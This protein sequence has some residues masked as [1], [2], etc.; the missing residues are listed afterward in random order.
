MAQYADSELASQWRERLGRFD[1]SDLTVAEFCRL[2]EYSVAAFYYW[3]GKLQAQETP[4]HFPTFVSVDV[5]KA[6]S[7]QS[8]SRGDLRIAIPG[9]AVIRVSLDAS[10]EQQQQLIKNA[11]VALREAQA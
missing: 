4:E 7:N 3:R 9:G 1:R 5:P 10:S 11:I 8:G 2:E 6:A